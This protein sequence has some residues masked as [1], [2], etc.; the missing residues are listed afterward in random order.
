MRNLPKKTNLHEI[1]CDNVPRRGILRST[2]VHLER[3]TEKMRR[4]LT[5]NYTVHNYKLFDEQKHEVR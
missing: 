3:E 2:A 4:N 1:K 5:K